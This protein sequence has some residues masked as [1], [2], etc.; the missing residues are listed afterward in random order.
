MLEDDLIAVLPELP[1]TEDGERG[2]V[3]R[4][5]VGRSWQLP[6]PGGCEVV[7]DMSMESAPESLGETTASYQVVRRLIRCIA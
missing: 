1:A 5:D 2:V 7:G 3:S 4:G 6:E